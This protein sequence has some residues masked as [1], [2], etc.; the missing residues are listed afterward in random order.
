MILASY[1][2]NV[3]AQSEIDADLNEYGHLGTACRTALGEAAIDAAL[4]GELCGRP[5]ATVTDA[6][7]NVLHAALD[8]G[9]DAD[10][11]CRAALDYVAEER[12]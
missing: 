1:T 2:V 4:H 5:M 7:A 12:S 9:L 11:V 8:R 10:A 6:V 3:P